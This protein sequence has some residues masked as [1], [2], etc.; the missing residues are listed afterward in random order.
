MYNRNIDKTYHGNTCGIF[1]KL[2]LSY[3]LYD[4]NENP[5]KVGISSSIIDEDKILSRI[6]KQFYFHYKVIGVY[7]SR[8]LATMDEFLHVTILKNNGASLPN[9]KKPDSITVLTKR[10]N[11][12]N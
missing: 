2:T 10:E 7:P 8:D 3:V 12:F 5:L 9:Q 4:S 6:K 11:Y 1:P